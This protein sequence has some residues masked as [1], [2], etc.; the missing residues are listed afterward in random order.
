MALLP[1]GSRALAEQDAVVETGS[2]VCRV[3]R[4]EGV[5]VLDRGGAWPHLGPPDLV[6]G[7]PPGD[8]QQPSARR[9]AARE[10]QHGPPI[11]FLGEVLDL[12]RF[13]QMREEAV[14]L[15]LG[16][17]NKCRKGAAVPTLAA[18]ASSVISS[19]SDRGHPC[20]GE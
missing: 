3:F 16:G 15:A 12:V 2:P 9:G 10:A 8:G 7:N 13:T 14:Y 6:G 4:Y 1:G 17:A 20:E 11:G 18:C 19:S 5:P